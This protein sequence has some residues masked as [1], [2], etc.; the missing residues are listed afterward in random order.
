MPQSALSGESGRAHK[1]NQSV[2]KYRVFPRLYYGESV[3]TGNFLIVVGVDVDDV[4][5]NSVNAIKCGR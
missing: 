5:Y 1:K 4:A 3:A 2:R